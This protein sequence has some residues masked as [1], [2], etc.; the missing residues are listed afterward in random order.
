MASTDGEILKQKFEEIF[1]E[2]LELLE[3]LMCDADCA[4]F[5]CDP[6]CPGTLTSHC[7]AEATGGE[8]EVFVTEP[9]LSNCPC[10]IASNIRKK[11]EKL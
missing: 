9:H 7:Q 3:K 2:E 8:G 11:L 10:V 5:L 4:H 6:G 1:K